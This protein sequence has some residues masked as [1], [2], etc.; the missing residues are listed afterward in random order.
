[1]RLSPRLFDHPEANGEAITIAE[2]FLDEGAAANFAS[3]SFCLSEQG[4]VEKTAGK[5][6]GGEGQ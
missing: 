1:M 3:G 5:G 4:L 2:Q 6:E